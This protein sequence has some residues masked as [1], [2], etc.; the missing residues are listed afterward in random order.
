MASRRAAS[1]AILDDSHDS[2]SSS[3]EDMPTTRPATHINLVDSDSGSESDGSE[4]DSEKDS[5]EDSD[6]NNGLIDMEASESD[7]DSDPGES[8]FIRRNAEEEGHQVEHW[9]PDEWKAHRKRIREERASQ[10]HEFPQFARLPY[11]LRRQ[12]WQ[13]HCPDLDGQPRLLW[14][15]ML[16][17]N[18]RDIAWYPTEG[19]YLMEQT[20]P[21]RSM[22]AVHRESRQMG[23]D[24]F[25]D[26]FNINCTNHS[27]RFNQARDIVY[28]ERV[29]RH[30]PFNSQTSGSGPK[31][32]CDKIQNLAVNCPSGPDWDE[33]SPFAPFVFD[34]TFILQFPSLVNVYPLYQKM[35][36]DHT[37]TWIQSSHCSWTT[38][39]TDTAG[40][41]L[42]YLGETMNWLI[43]W[44]KPVNCKAEGE[45]AQL[46]SRRML[47]FLGPQDDFDPHLEPQLDIGSDDEGQDSSV[48][49]FE[50][51]RER[52]ES[53]RKCPMAVFGHV[54]HTGFGGVRV[55]ERGFGSSGLRLMNPDK[56]DW[57]DDCLEGDTEDEYESEGIDDAPI[58]DPETEDEDEGSGIEDDTLAMELVSHEHEDED[59]TGGFSPVQ[60]SDSE[61]ADEMDSID[62]A[63]APTTRTRP[64]ILDDTD[65]EDENTHREPTP[66]RRGRKRQ[67]IVSDDE[68]DEEPEEAR[69]TKRRARQIVEDD[70]DDEE[71]EVEVEVR[72]KGSRGGPVIISDSEE[73]AAGSK[74]KPASVD[75]DSE[76]DSEEED[77]SDDDPPARPLS[78]AERLRQNREANPIPIGSDEDSEEDSENGRYGGYDE[79]SDDDGEALEATMADDGS[80]ENDD[81]DDYY[82]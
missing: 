19:R 31:T 1:R 10:L 52:L 73:D 66:P 21:L 49:I 76:K 78:L 4:E 44:H 70:S 3:S 33:S 8:G 64:I 13:F 35:L 65:D 62:N 47:G 2:D 42:D 23:V 38:M 60:I 26:S 30:D 22:M 40:D 18:S 74:A 72:S 82:R 16:C 9:G 14:L 36:A 80:D 28:L 79:G 29:Y 15:Q 54:L 34:L 81:E 37:D 7:D 68:E 45:C 6:E 27:V 69:P 24:M 55:S 39:A 75:S 12:I 20:Q 50:H 17:S 5:E 53:I 59:A 57:N 32:F 77:D 58:P 25:P 11:E 61:T 46:K 51:A 71:V 48:Y 67:R 56:D 43:C 41:T 63:P